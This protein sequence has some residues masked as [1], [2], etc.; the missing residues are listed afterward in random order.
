MPFDPTT[1]VAV[2]ERSDGLIE[3]DVFDPT[4]AVPIPNDDTLFRTAIPVEKEPN[5]KLSTGG[6]E[7]LKKTA[8]IPVFGFPTQ[9]VD[10]ESVRKFF[11]N[12]GDQ[13]K[14]G[15][16]FEKHYTPPRSD[17]EKAEAFVALT[18]K[19]EGKDVPT[20]LKIDWALTSQSARSFTKAAIW[21]GITGGLYPLVA[22]G[23]GLAESDTGLPAG[24]RAKKGLLFPEHTKEVYEKIPGSEEWP[25]WARVLAGVSETIIK[26]GVA[27]VGKQA[28]KARLFA[29][30]VASKAYAAASERAKE[31]MMEKGGKVV[32]EKGV[33][34]TTEE[35]AL[36]AKWE[37]QTRDQLLNA[38]YNKMGTVYSDTLK[39]G[40]QEE[41]KKANIFNLLGE[42]L[43]RRGVGMPKGLSMNPIPFTGQTVSFTEGGKKLV[44][45]ILDVVGDRISID[46]GGSIVY[47]TQEQLIGAVA[48]HGTT[49]DF[50][51]FSLENAEVE[52]D[53]G[54]GIYFSSSKYDVESNYSTI[55]GADITNKIERLAE[56]LEN[57]TELTAGEALEEAKKQL[58]VK[59]G[60][61]L[62]VELDLEN[63]VVLGGKDETIFEMESL[64]DDEGEYLDEEPMGTLIDFI[65]GL[66]QTYADDANIDET[67]SEI[68]EAAN[69]ESISASELVDLLKNSE[70]LMYATDDEGRLVGNEI[71][72]N[73]FENMGYDSIVDK[74]VNQ[75]FGTARKMGKSMEGVDEETIHYVVFD[76]KQV[77]M[78][79]KKIEPKVEESK[80]I[81]PSGWDVELEA[82]PEQIKPNKKGIS[83]LDEKIQKLKDNE[84][85]Q[86]F[87]KD[88]LENLKSLQ[89][90]MKGRIRPY[91]EGKGD[92]FEEYQEI[93]QKYRSK[94]VEDGIS[95]D[96]AA[97]ELS[98][99]GLEVSEASLADYLAD[100]DS[101]ILSLRSQIKELKTPYVRMKEMTQLKNRIRD[102]SRGI[103]EGKVAAK[104]E[105][106]DVGSQV[107]KL[108]ANSELDTADK[109]VFL[110]TMKKITTQEQLEAARPAI[111]ERIA[112][113]EEIKKKRKLIKQFKDLSKSG[114]IK[115]LR[116]EY[117][118]AVQNIVDQFDVAKISDA[119]VADLGK[120]ADYLSA[121][122]ENN[123]PQERIDQLKRLEKTPL[124]DLTS[125]EIET[126]VSSIRH[127][128]KLNEL[129]NKLIVK[130]KLKD[131]AKVVNEAVSNVQKKFGELDG[132]IDGLDSLMITPEDKALTKFI[133]G[134]SANPE[135][136][137]EILDG[138][139][140][141]IIQE[142]MYK[143]I[144]KGTDVQLSFV[145]QAEDF[146]K[147][148]LAGINMDA[149]S[150]SFQLKKKDIIQTPF[151]LH[152]H[153]NPIK[154]TPGEKIAFYLHTLNEQNLKHLVD[155]GFSFSG[156]PTKIIKFNDPAD[157]WNIANSLTKDEQ[158]VADAINEYLN[159]IQKDGLNEVSVRLNGFEVAVVDN[160]FSIR[161]NF[162]DRFKDELLK[163]QAGL[164]AEVS[165]EGMGIFK[166]RQDTGNAIILE[167]VFVAVA[168]SVKQS[169]A[170]IGL[171]EPLRSAKALLNDNEFQKAVIDA[172]KGYYLDQLKDY[173][174]KVEGEYTN[175]DDLDKLTQAMMNKFDLSVLGANP[176]VVAKQPVSYLLASTEIDGKFL[177]DSF[178]LKATPE[179]LAEIEMYCP[180]LWERIAGNVSREMGEVMNVG[181]AKKFFTGKDTGLQ[182]IMKGISAA[183]ASA[184]SS[185]WR[186]VKK[187]VS[188]QF[189]SLKGK[190]FFA[191]C[192]ERAWEVTR[193]TQP[194]F[195]VKDRS[196]IGRRKDWFFRLL[197]KYSSQRNKNLMIQRRA[198][199]KYNRSH[200]T[201]KD[202]AA[203]WNTLFL[204]NVV[205]AFFIAAINKTRSVILNRAVPKS[206]IHKKEESNI[207]EEF[208]IE[209]VNSGVGNIYFLGTAFNSL[210][211]KLQ[212]GTYGG[213]DISDPVMGTINQA[214]DT[215]T[216]MANVI[217][218]AISN[219][220][221]KPEV[222]R[223]IGEKKWK[224][225]LK[226][227]VVNSVDLSGKFLG[228]NIQLWRKF[229][230][231]Q[232]DRVTGK[233]KKKNEIRLP[234]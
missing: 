3:A 178:G 212:R 133:S 227:S 138:V 30:N 43:K 217:T 158:R 166:T 91:K 47:A 190:E 41:F 69:Y 83:L 211:S 78:E 93:P 171:A 193:R 201:P 123:V 68:M 126:I 188:A 90:G 184:I 63:P 162:L 154:I 145:K 108:L 189:P 79:Q 77:K 160:Y 28:V 196:P 4:T 9:P 200:K 8:P 25:T 175:M 113:I 88:A 106:L 11:P 56:D 94:N 135:L 84:L 38:W 6:A 85:Q 86:D 57:D 148:K 97:M 92:L 98:E 110:S 187:E 170:Y 44:G 141:G 34:I 49:K 111:E 31:M 167:D 45:K 176:F 165:L 104:K 10:I 185:I 208:V 53:L 137:G 29:R 207:V 151:K 231:A 117:K 129:K 22:A 204:V 180:Q 27:S 134:Y 202:K 24:E 214:I 17:K 61:L 186:A 218:Y 19:E 183:D 157:I 195:H 71:I 89:S 205:S 152:G 232:Y 139:D 96:E 100:L 224:E 156:T 228:L 105:V 112:K 81:E 39:T 136:K 163:G 13:I 131:H 118:K 182:W 203:V 169:A 55:E 37:A 52:S 7:A 48:Y 109:G 40:F 72:R 132:S 179:E 144:D 1:A 42:E 125:D 198:Y 66:K 67:V 65:D 225:A 124:K 210:I 221:Y 54:A 192:Y 120:L 215:I 149:W 74:T 14:S 213:F 32:G 140:N 62:K 164:V 199:E 172:G 64:I 229:I 101:Q 103:R 216:E 234:D 35:V 21:T 23:T 206:V 114:D 73:A 177:K 26:Y 95:M 36:A 168:K 150:S 119:K 60:K 142:V 59:K 122:P 147:E 161:T 70:G 99:M 102:I 173:L 226:K 219:E 222:G 15:G 80:V 46:L 50:K 116:P 5:T 87:A 115:K 16:Y 130:G 220:R 76:P 230:V 159:T 33:G 143:G 121:T 12:K 194:T 2:R 82:A 146:F 18:F 233:N 20:A 223:L 51:V 58:G 155:G 181:F 153:K 209:M 191:K 75:K 127:L 107:Q 197:T 128:L 174:L